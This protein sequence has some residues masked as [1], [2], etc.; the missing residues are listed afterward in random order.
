M[1][2]LYEFV[3]KEL[4]GW[5]INEFICHLY[6]LP[7]LS[8]L[9]YRVWSFIESSH[10]EIQDATRNTIYWNYNVY[11]YACVCIFLILSTETKS[12]LIIFLV[13][14]DRDFVLY[15]SPWLV[16]FSNPL[17]KSIIEQKLFVLTII[18]NKSNES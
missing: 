5:W 7:S 16:L 9:I 13:T 15:P 12:Y 11:L 17:F 1:D 14:K 3:V 10:I 6:L 4:D 2:R 8:L 18:F